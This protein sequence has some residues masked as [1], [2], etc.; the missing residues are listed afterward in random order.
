MTQQ[1]SPTLQA[2]IEWA[3]KGTGATQGWLLAVEGQ[4][5]VV[6]AAAGGE[7]PGAQVG[8][9]LTPT[10]AAGFAAGSGQPAA[11]QPSADDVS[12][13]GAGGSGGVPSSLIATPCVGDEVVGVL[14]IVEKQ[15]GGG[16]TIDDIEI[17]SLLAEIA[18]AALA[19][20]ADG[21]IDVPTPA[22]LGVELAHVAEADL[23]RYAEIARAIQ[24]L[25]GQA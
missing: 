2:I 12:N 8:R 24:S 25:L 7:R 22:E 18:A 21:K 14:E 1:T 5:L 19:E 9:R 23:S 11:L 4:E 13:E 16:F 17:T 3:V 20:L 10:G 15:G 6:A